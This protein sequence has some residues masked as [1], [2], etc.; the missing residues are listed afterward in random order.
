MML[1]G[2][3][4]PQKQHPGRRPERRCPRT[5]RR[6]ASGCIVDSAFLP[7]R[8]LGRPIR[9]HSKNDNRFRRA[10]PRGCAAKRQHF[11]E[12]S[13]DDTLPSHQDCL[14]GF[15]HCPRARRPAGVRFGLRAG[16]AECDGTRQRLCRSRGRRRGREHR[17]VQPRGSR[18]AQFS[19]GRGG[20][21]CDH[22]VGQV[23]ECEL[24]AGA[25]ATAGRHGRRRRQRR[26]RAESLRLDGHQRPHPRRDRRQR[27]LRS[28]DGI[29]RRLARPLSG[30]QVR[31][32]DDQRQPVDILQGDRPVL[33]RRRGELSAFRRDAHQQRELLGGAGAGLRQDA[34][35][36]PDH[37]GA[38]GG[39][40]CGD[41][42]SGYV[43][44]GHRRRLIV[45]ME[46]RRDVQLQR[47]CQ[48]RPRG[49]KNRPR[50]SV[51]DQVQRRRQRQL[52]QSD[53]PDVDRRA[54]PVQPGGRASSA[55]RS[56]RRASTMAA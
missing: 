38:G 45:G 7:E 48:Q 2:G 42:G 28:Q 16:R 44:Q 34:A 49:G 10:T 53:A 36:R 46:R 37:A 9:D 47:R 51:E 31:S 5:V 20:D 55:A 41:G 54:C 14:G 6:P 12:I 17:V 13:H 24:A 8:S 18:A 23:P 43:R 4:L 52:H 39:I 40:E 22:P 35:A 27:P 21:P 3:L 33:D 26:V 15:R 56:T 1:R 32:Q 29:R 50:L 30:A 25:P 11:G 19:A